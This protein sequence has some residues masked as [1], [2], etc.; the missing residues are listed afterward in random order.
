[1]TGKKNKAAG[2]TGL[3]LYSSAIGGSLQLKDGCMD[4]RDSYCD[5]LASSPRFRTKYSRGEP[6]LA[7]GTGMDTGMGYLDSQCKGLYQQGLV[8]MV[9]WLSGVPRNTWGKE[10]G[11]ILPWL[12]NGCQVLRS[13]RRRKLFTCTTR[14]GVALHH[15][16][17]RRRLRRRL[18]LAASH[19]GWL[20]LSFCGFIEITGTN[21]H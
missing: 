13:D 16:P 5:W 3:L 12:C 4:E 15:P 14:S 11:E 17:S 7:W 21:D 10:K 2:R 9:P 20:P 19:R 6:K 1:M 18:S 8:H